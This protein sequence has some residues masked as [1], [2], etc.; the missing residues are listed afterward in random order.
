MTF[1]FNL[2][3]VSLQS[4]IKSPIVKVPPMKK[5]LLFFSNP[6]KYGGEGEIRTHGTLL[7]YTRFPIVLL[8]PARTPLRG[9]AN[10]GTRP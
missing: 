4:P 8:R 5:G 1:R 10:A 6:L 7:T 3:G 2:I 9:W